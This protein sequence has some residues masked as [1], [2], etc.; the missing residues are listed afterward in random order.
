MKPYIA[1]IRDCFHE[2]FVSRV[3]WIVVGLITL[4]LLALAPLSITE[5]LAMKIRT[6]EVFAPKQLM[7]QIAK[8]GKEDSQTPAADIWGL[9]DEDSKESIDATLTE[10]EENR[11]AIRESLTKVLDAINEIEDPKVLF[12]SDAFGRV[13]LPEEAQDLMDRSEGLSDEEG[14]RLNRFLVG[15]AFPRAIFLRDSTETHVSYFIW[16]NDVDAIPIPK[17]ELLKNA[18]TAVTTFLLG[19]LG[20]MLAILITAT[21][22]PQTFDKGAIDLLLSKPLN[23][24]FLFLAKYVGGC[25]F[26]TICTAYM[27]GG[28]C[29]LAALRWDYWEPRMLLGIPIFLFL[30]G[31]YYSVSAF[32]GVIWRNPVVSVFLT[33]GFWF[34][35]AS[36][37]TSRTVIRDMF[38]ASSQATTILPIESAPI[39]I[40]ESNII[41]RWT[42]EDAIEPWSV[43]EDVSK[44]SGLPGQIVQAVGP[45]Y[46][47]DQRRIVSLRFRASGPGRRRS[48]GANSAAMI[49][50]GSDTEW[51]LDDGPELTDRP[52]GI[53]SDDDGGI[54]VTG[55]R[56]MQ[57]L[58]V[59]SDGK[60][61][62]KN[63]GPNIGMALPVTVSL[64][65]TTR[66][67]AIWDGAKLSVYLVDESGKYKL[68]LEKQLE[69]L[70]QGLVSFRG[71]VIAIVTDDGDLTTFNAT[72]LEETHAFSR[73]DDS[74]PR[75][76]ESSKDGLWTAVVYHDGSLRVADQMKESWSEPRVAER[77]NVFAVAFSDDGNLWVSG[78]YRRVS[79]YDP[80]TM[81]SLEKYWPEMNTME[82]IERYALEPVYTIF[83]K[84]GELSSVIAYLMTGEESVSEDADNM[85]TRRV[86]LNIW[87][88]IWSNLAFLCV[89]LGLA[90]IHIQRKD[91]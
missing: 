3:L 67:I 87:G 78:K 53:F 59:D 28:L 85:S 63:I 52:I 21:M 22:I 5:Q 79:V 58:L 4:L 61:F 25:A 69:Q 13:T 11:R 24:S 26:I 70:G 83:P 84:P 60:E 19:T 73:S 66:R 89:T 1:I 54:T 62:F 7:V 10:K 50:G 86:K 55:R 6:V 14:R 68:S 57:R 39:A 88:T 27:V 23:R 51:T 35:C 45:V 17:D 81:R 56:G 49:V 42:N 30:F 32:A 16:G 34:L 18:L 31:I 77:K 71:E 76:I 38:L 43:L 20:V 36:V 72:D 47:A 15:A 65:P 74:P 8:E 48:A 90:C 33:I 91:F 2:A 82:K 41:A 40:S 37:G 80:E 75:Y 64:D 29:L 9:L 44:T 46:D 12:G